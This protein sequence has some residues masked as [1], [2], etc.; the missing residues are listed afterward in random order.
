MRFTDLMIGTSLHFDAAL[1]KGSGNVECGEFAKSFR[2]RHSRC[3]R[4]RTSGQR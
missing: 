4:R 2:C 1:A 3:P